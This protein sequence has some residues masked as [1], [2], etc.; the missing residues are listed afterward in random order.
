MK[1]GDLVRQFGV[2]DTTIRRWVAEF[3]EFLSENAKQ[4]RSKHR[5]FT[6]DDFLVLA[7]AHEMSKENFPLN[8]IRE[9]LAEGY[10]VDDTTAST[11]GY[12]DGRLVPAVAVEQIIDSTE[13]RIELEQVRA[14]RDKLVEALEKLEASKTELVEKHDQHLLE[15]DNRL[16]ALQQQISALQRE[17]GRAEGEL[18]YRRELDGKSEI[19][20]PDAD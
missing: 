1:T 3:E 11:V 17:L 13:L 12:S 8:A 6:S 7:T 9:K 20:K 19:I 4:T 2:S 18:A 15:K 10:R 5:S 16:A 14:E